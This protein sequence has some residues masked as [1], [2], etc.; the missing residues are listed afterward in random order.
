MPAI[1]ATP[2]STSIIGPVSQ[3]NLHH[4]VPASDSADV[5]PRLVAGGLTWI[6]MLHI[7]A[8]ASRSNWR[9]RQLRPRSKHGVRMRNL[10]GAMQLSQTAALRSQDWSRVR[11]GPAARGLRS[12][13]GWFRAWTVLP[14]PRSCRAARRLAGVGYD[15]R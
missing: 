11:K 10:P 12:E 4:C 5:C 6:R 7:S 2:I 8:R 9:P 15:I 13:R 3:A 14:R 1:S